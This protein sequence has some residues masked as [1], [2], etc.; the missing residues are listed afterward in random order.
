MKQ[1]VTD[2]PETVVAKNALAWLPYLLKAMKGDPEGLY[3]FL[4]EIE[5]E[6]LEDTKIETKAIMKTSEKEYAEAI[7][8]YEEIIND[9]PNDYKQLIAELDGAFCYYKLVTSGERNLPD[10]CKR[11]P[12]DFG[13]YS[14]IKQ[15]IQTQLLLGNENNNQENQILSIPV[16][17]SNYPN[18]FNPETTIS[19]SIPEESNV[20][21]T[22]FNIKGQKVK[23]LINSS[24]DK[25]NH[26]IIWNGKNEH[27]KS[28]ASGVYF[29]KF[30]VND[31]TK[32]IKKCLMLK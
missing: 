9:P 3:A 10:N 28:V 30:D 26:S 13:E 6:N 23:T 12:K 17:N 14:Q 31:K 29:Y 7:S 11:K 21:L 19:F 27:N 24:L 25:G 20:E 1:I 16:L 32:S 22:I 2:Y 15:E 5:H 8:L 18:P 4:E